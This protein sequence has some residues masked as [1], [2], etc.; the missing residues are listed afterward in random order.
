M[1]MLASPLLMGQAPV[2][3]ALEAAALTPVEIA[4][5][6]AQQIPYEQ[7]PQTVLALS[8]SLASQEQGEGPP[9]EGADEGIGDDPTQENPD[10]II[11]EGEIGP[12]ERDPAAEFNATSYRITQDLDNVFLEPVAYAYRD[13]LPDPLRDGLGNVVKNLGEPTNFIN[14]LLQGKIGKAFE[15]LGRFAINSSIGLG[16]LIDIAGKKNIGLPHRRNGFANTLAFY[17]AEP[18]AYLYLPVTGATTVRD[19]IGNGFNQLP[20]PLIVGKPFNTPEYTI[21]FFVI[22]S[23]DERLE[24]DEELQ[25]IDA[26]IDPYVARRESYL[27]TRERDIALLKGEPVPPKPNIVRE[28]LDGEIDYGDEELDEAGTD[29]L[30]T[31]EAV[32]EMP[33][34]PKVKPSDA[35]AIMG[36]SQ[37]NPGAVAITR[38]R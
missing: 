31:D 11:V 18:G 25:R 29:E 38:P 6:T 19:L 5:L 17:G 30:G 12:S 13:G 10:V 35:P 4:G 20:L 28:V 24:V 14:F 22:S 3:A 33:G 36:A 1:M 26:T 8:W 16:G 32:D 2:N 23:L 21:P 34:E 9:E 15:T 27:W 7:P 37:V